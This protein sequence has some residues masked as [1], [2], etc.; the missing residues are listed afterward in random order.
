MLDAMTDLPAYIRN[1]R[2]DILA[3]NSL[4]QALCARVY[5]SRLFARCGPVNTA[6]FL[7]V[8]PG[9]ADFWPG[10]RITIYSPEPDSP[11]RQALDLLTS[12][13]GSTALE[14]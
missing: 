7:F 11:E 14:H 8:D 1:G 12:W 13:I 6:R 3:A 2:F 5:D 4:G 10:L 9:S